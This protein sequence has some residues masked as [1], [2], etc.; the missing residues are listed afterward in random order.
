MFLAVLGC[1]ARADGS[2]SQSQQTDQPLLLDAMREGGGVDLLNPQAHGVVEDD[3]QE[4][5]PKA[6]TVQGD[7]ERAKLKSFLPQKARRDI[8]IFALFGLRL[9]IQ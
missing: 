7:L 3:L 4:S 8:R 6:E 1:L 9:E 5:L 2:R